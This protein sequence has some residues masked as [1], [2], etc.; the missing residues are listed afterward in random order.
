MVLVT[1]GDLE[2]CLAAPPADAGED[3]AVL[4]MGMIRFF[5]GLWMVYGI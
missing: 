1:S 5:S 2:A 4:Q 3:Q